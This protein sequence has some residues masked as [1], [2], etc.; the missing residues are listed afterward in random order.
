MAALK[1][2]EE[3]LQND[4]GDFGERVLEVNREQVHTEYTKTCVTRRAKELFCHSKELPDIM[5]VEKAII[6]EFGQAAWD[7]HGTQVVT[8]SS[9]FDDDI[10]TPIHMHS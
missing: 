5:L 8:L 9:M 7:E 6:D 1:D 4:F 3:T 2:V 10:N